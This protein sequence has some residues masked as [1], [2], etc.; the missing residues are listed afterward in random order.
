MEVRI[1]SFYAHF[2]ALFLIFKTSLLFLYTQ[3]LM[4]PL[5]ILPFNMISQISAANSS[6]TPFFQPVFLKVFMF[7]SNPFTKS[8]L[9]LMILLLC[10]DDKSFLLYLNLF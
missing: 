1:H 8:P 9:Q 4:L 10:I 3:L 6:F 2:N 7:V 5:S